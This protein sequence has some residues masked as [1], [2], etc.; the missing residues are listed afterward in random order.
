[1][2]KTISAG[3]KDLDEFLRDTQVAD[4]LGVN[5]QTL[6]KWRVMGKGPPFKRFGR[7]I[8]YSKKTV[9]EWFEE[10]PDQQS[11]SG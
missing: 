8:R 10:H 4:I 7:M 1:M 5:F 2:R 3:K 11:T 6:Q 9:K